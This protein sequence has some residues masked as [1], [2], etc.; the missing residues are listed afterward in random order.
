MSPRRSR[1]VSPFRRASLSTT[2]IYKLRYYWR[3]TLATDE[4][5]LLS[6]P[7]R[8]FYLSSRSPRRRHHLLDHVLHRGGT[9]RHDGSGRDGP[10]RCLYGHLPGQRAGHLPHGLP[11]QLPHCPGARNGQ[12]RLLRLRGGLGDGDLLGSCS[13]GSLH[14]GRPLHSSSQRRLPRAH[15][16][17]RPELSENGYRGRHRAAHRFSGFAVGRPPDGEPPGYSDHPRGF[18]AAG[19]LR[20]A[21][22]PGCNGCA[23]RLESPRRVGGG[24]WGLPCWDCGRV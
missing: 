2:E 9:A 18:H 6:G 12:Q 5:F 16:G 8:R 17:R 21:L 20:S 4:A 23:A 3:T 19:D 13:R 14:F 15:Y 7:R 22:R 11:G 10:G 24:Y 1:L